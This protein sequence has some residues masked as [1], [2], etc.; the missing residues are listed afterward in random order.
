MRG[1][2]RKQPMFEWVVYRFLC[3]VAN[4][5]LSA[6]C[7]QCLTFCDVKLFIILR[8]HNEYLVISIRRLKMK[9]NLRKY[10]RRT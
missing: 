9:A 8:R 5:M 3:D 2:H 1:G 10:R 4:L 6:R 7:E